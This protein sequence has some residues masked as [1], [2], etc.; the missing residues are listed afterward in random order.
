MGRGVAELTSKMHDIWHPV[1]LRGL[2]LMICYVA[3]QDT[4]AF[5]AVHNEGGRPFAVHLRE[6]NLTVLK[7]RIRI[8]QYSFNACRVMLQFRARMPDR[9]PALHTS[10]RRDGG[11]VIVTI[12]SDHVKKEIH[13]GS[14]A[15]EALYELL[16]THNDVIKN[17]IKV[18]D[19]SKNLKTGGTV[20]RLV[21]I[22][23]QVLPA[24]EAALKQAVRCVLNCLHGLHTQ[25]TAYNHRDIRWPNVLKGAIETDWF[26]IDFENAD[27]EGKVVNWVDNRGMHPPEATRK[28][29]WTCASDIWQVGRLVQCWNSDKAGVLS[30]AGTQFM[31]LLLSNEPASR[32][33]AAVAL[34]HA[35]LA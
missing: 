3:A 33:T 25:K 24:D 10:M 8:V 34:G 23:S 16:S 27:V 4:L 13:A 15:P 1:A 6:F 31:Q 19:C 20:L 22:G 14:T 21:P 35:W 18:S 32:P 29:P 12:N 30:A 11:N 5:Y 28:E 26:L 9:V 7:D 2:P 17:A